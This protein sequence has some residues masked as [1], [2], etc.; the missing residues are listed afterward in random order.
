M[1]VPAV[2]GVLALAVVLW[3]S[4]LVVREQQA[5]RARFRPIAERVA[6]INGGQQARAFRRA[7]PEAAAVV[8]AGALPVPVRRRR[9]VCP[10]PSVSP[11]FDGSGHTTSTGRHA[12]AS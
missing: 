8:Q 10:D 9:V 4:V 7:H 2:I 11:T 12:R 1:S 6:V 3:T 5:R